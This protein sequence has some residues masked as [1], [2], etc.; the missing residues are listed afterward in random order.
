MTQTNLTVSGFEQIFGDAYQ[1]TYTPEANYMLC[2]KCDDG[3]P[4]TYCPGERGDEFNAPEPEG[5]MC[6]VCDEFTARHE[7][8]EN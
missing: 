5:W 4:H 2:R 6:D 7:V 3:T 8:D 1:R